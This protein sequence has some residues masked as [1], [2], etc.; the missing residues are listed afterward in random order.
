MTI[1]AIS[2]GSLGNVRTQTMRAFSADDMNS[3]VAKLPKM[4]I[5]S[6]K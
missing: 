2:L 6:A 1:L 3:I 4:D 5:V